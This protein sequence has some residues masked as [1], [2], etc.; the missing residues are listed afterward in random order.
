V[1]FF[2]AKPGQKWVSDSTCLRALNGWLY[3]T[4]G[5][6]LF[7]R[8]VIGWAIGDTLETANTSIPAFKMAVKNRTAEKD[9]I[10]HSD[11]GIQ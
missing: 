8:E 11:R 2:A 10:F 5:I 4:V 6:D 3:L 7:D 9:L 1:I